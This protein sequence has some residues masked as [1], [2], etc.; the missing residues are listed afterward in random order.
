MKET[1]LKVVRVDKPRSLRER[2][3]EKKRAAILGA[4]RELLLAHGYDATT[5]EEI[6]MRA[7][8]GVA[9]TYKYFGSKYALAMELVRGDLQEVLDEVSVIIEQPPG[10]LIET[11]SAIFEKLCNLQLTKDWASF[12]SHMI[13]KEWNAENFG[14]SQSAIW[15]KTESQRKFEQVLRHFRKR[16]EIKTPIDIQAT[17]TAIYSLFDYNYIR[18]PRGELQRL[19]EVMSVTQ[20]QIGMLCGLEE[21]SPPDG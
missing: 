16:G 2:N 6:S 19:E 5:M 1:T 4:A 7:E 13:G 8:V 17:A 18:F 15:L 12:I 14:G 11:F 10:G 21:S 20:K 3:K 9:T